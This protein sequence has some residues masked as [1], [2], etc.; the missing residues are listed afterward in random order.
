MH[1]FQ[2]RLAITALALEAGHHHVGDHRLEA[3]VHRHA[4]GLAGLELALA[5][6]ALVH[7]QLQRLAMTLG[8]GIALHQL[9]R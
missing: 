5:V 7:R 8:L 2:H 1:L 4:P 3:L 6:A 9:E